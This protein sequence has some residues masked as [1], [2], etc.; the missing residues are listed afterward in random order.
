MEPLQYLAAWDVH[1]AMLV[2]RFESRLGKT[3]FRSAGRRCEDPG[4]VRSARR[5]FWIVDN[6]SSQRGKRRPKSCKPFASASWSCTRRCMPVGSTRSPIY[7]SMLQRKVL[8][9]NDHTNLEDFVE[10]I[11]AFGNRYSAL[12][13]PDCVTRPHR[14]GGPA[15]GCRPG[16]S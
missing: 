10:R 13:M 1:R 16:Q 14:R 8:R 11:N 9:P 4:I 2:G 6:G 15:P 7:F 5:V 3:A 12:G